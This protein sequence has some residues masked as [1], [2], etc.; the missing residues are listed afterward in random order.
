MGA[1]LYGDCGPMETQATVDI[2][3]T[4]ALKIGVRHLLRTWAGHRSAAIIALGA[5][6]LAG[7][8][9]FRGD[10]E[11]HTLL[12]TSSTLLAIGIG[13]AALVRY[14][15]LR[16][17]TIFFVGVAFVGVACFEAFHAAATSTWFGSSFESELSSL[18]P[19]SWL[20][21]RLFFSV[22]LTASVLNWRTRGNDQAAGFR[23]ERWLFALGAGLALAN[24]MFFALAPLP[25]AYFPGLLFGRPEELIPAAFLA[26]AL[27]GH[28]RRR[29]S[30]VGDFEHWLLLSFIAGLGAQ[31]AMSLSTGLFDTQFFVAHVLKFGSYVLVFVGLLVSTYRTFSQ[32]ETARHQLISVNAELSRSNAVL[33]EKNQEL[34]RSSFPILVGAL[35]EGLV[36]FDGEGRITDINEQAAEMYGVDRRAAIGR[37]AT[38]S[39]L[40]VTFLMPDGTAPRYGELPTVQ[41]YLEARAERN[42]SVIV[43]RRDGSIIHLRSNSAPII[44][45]GESVPSGVMVTYTDVTADAQREAARLE[46][47]AEVRRL[48][49]T[50]S[51]TG[52]PNRASF[53]EHLDA[54]V[55]ARRAADAGGVAVL[56]LD[57]DRFKVVNDAIDHAT[58]DEVLCEAARRITSVLRANDLAARLGGDEFA[59]VLS[60]IAEDQDAVA[61]AD[62]LLAEFR[63]PWRMKRDLR[64]T[65]SIGIARY[66]DHGRDSASLLQSADSAMYDAK[67]RGRD[68]WA[69]YRTALS[70][71]AISTLTLEAD[72]ERAFKR[73]EFELYYQPVAH[74]ESGT[75]VGAE[76]LIRWHHPT[77]GLLA[78]RDFLGVAE[79]SGLILRLDREVL[80]M[81]CGQAREWQQAG[82]PRIRIATNLSA[83]HFRGDGVSDWVASMVRESDL[84]PHDLQ[85][86]ISESTVITELSSAASS[87][88][89]LRAL[90]VSIAVDDFGTG[91]SALSYLRRLPADVLKIDQSFVAG[92]DSEA[93]DRAIVSAII[94]LAASLG[95]DVI[96]EGVETAEQLEVLAGL[97]C[98]EY[99]G[100]YFAPALPAAEFAELLR[101][102]QITR[103]SAA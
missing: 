27:L 71:Q 91:Y 17:R 5:I 14:Y 7:G 95:L 19:W 87:I 4:A 72:L 43:K 47:E 67:V 53:R 77:Q 29:P 35:A 30:T 85:L 28:Y 45:A 101:K 83:R 26:F 8:V 94:A 36:V 21:A 48:A 34:E 50:D 25:R 80:R 90:G 32:V 15:S 97:G 33:Q 102:A 1:H 2:P 51:L 41:A 89:E 59:I 9:G 44:S 49:Y 12:E 11:L 13:A 81:A 76:A 55:R 56:F 64:L 57:L 73:N 10:A 37:R 88:D 24:F 69:L 20:S 62:R 39:D 66:P 92:I 61:I 75:I 100:N 6:V 103:P 96:A 46:A 16:D 22:L 63:E 18:V 38:S 93:S 68:Q 3:R 99:Q 52:L 54:A 58:G 74:L 98:G 23:Y 60:D 70:E 65:A 79:E 86:E 40:G 84:D 82:L 42:R 31:L 78:P